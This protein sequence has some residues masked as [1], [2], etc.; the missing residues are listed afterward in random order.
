MTLCSARTGH[1]LVLAAQAVLV[2]QAVP[3]T[4][5]LVVQEELPEIPGMPRVAESSKQV[6]LSSSTFRL[7]REMLQLLHAWLQPEVQ[8]G[9]QQLREEPVRVGL[10]LWVQ[11]LWVAASSMCMEGLAS[12]T[13]PSSLAT[14]LLRL[15]VERVG[16]QVPE[17]LPQLQGQ[18]ESVDR[19]LVGDSTRRQGLLPSHRHLLPRTKPQALQAV[20]GALAETAAPLRA[21]AST[22]KPET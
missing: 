5:P 22:S 15:W 13:I 9:T 18:A 16:Q 4:V 10:V 14:R 20:W 8:A 21:A 1:S 17:Q 12:Q 19:P 11:M 3:A 2:A 7:C 6:G